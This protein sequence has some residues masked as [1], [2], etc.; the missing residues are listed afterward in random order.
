[1]GKEYLDT[2]IT[3]QSF[4]PVSQYSY[5]EWDDLLDVA[6]CYGRDRQIQPLKH[7]LKQYEKWLYSEETESNWAWG[8]GMPS[9]QGVVE[10]YEQ[11]KKEAL[12]AMEARSN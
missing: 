7:H 10:D 8:T 3:R 11:I 2:V 5:F 9:H 12:K 6:K 1:M 4:P